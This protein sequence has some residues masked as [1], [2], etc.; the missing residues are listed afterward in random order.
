ME[1]VSGTYDDMNDMIRRYSCITI[2][3][4]K[5]ILAASKGQVRCVEASSAAQVFPPDREV[6]W[7]NFTKQFPF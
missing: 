3:E 2:L 6:H 7:V 4:D 1:R 5:V